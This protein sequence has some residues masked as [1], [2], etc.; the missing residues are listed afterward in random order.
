ME[1][2]KLTSGRTESDA[3]SEIDGIPHRSI[4]RIATPGSGPN[5]L[6]AQEAKPARSGAKIKGDSKRIE[7]RDEKERGRKQSRRREEATRAEARPETRAP[8][9]EGG[10]ESAGWRGRTWAPFIAGGGGGG[11]GRPGANRIL[12]G[13]GFVFAALAVVF[14]G[15][16]G[17]GNQKRAELVDRAGS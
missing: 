12:T 10:G 14:R 6:R 5:P 7:M 3:G 2:E 13:H 4:D 17:G 16:V 1:F 9:R 11:G 8:K 15:R